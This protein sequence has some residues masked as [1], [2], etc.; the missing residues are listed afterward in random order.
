MDMKYFANLLETELPRIPYRL[1]CSPRLW[2]T[3]SGFLG[4]I[5]LDV[6]VRAGRPRPKQ[7]NQR[8]PEKQ[9]KS[10]RAY[11]QKKDIAWTGKHLPKQCLTVRLAQHKTTANRPS[12]HSLTGTCPVVLSP[13]NWCRFAV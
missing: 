6:D 11:Q 8:T 12:C 4:L 1:A 3:F 10:G 13:R 2:P 9:N 7:H 5:G